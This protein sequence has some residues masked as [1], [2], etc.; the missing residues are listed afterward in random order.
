MVVV[1]PT[2]LLVKVAM[3]S[4]IHYKKFSLSIWDV[5][6]Y[7]WALL[8]LLW[9]SAHCPWFLTLPSSGNPF[10]R[11]HQQLLFSHFSLVLSLSVCPLVFP[12]MRHVA[13]GCGNGISNKTECCSAMESYV[14]HLQKQSLVTNLQALNCATTLGMKLQRSNI[15]KD[16]YSLC[17]ITLKDFSLQGWCFQFFNKLFFFFFSLVPSPKSQFPSVDILQAFSFRQI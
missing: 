7:F 12:D 10:S 8:I 1:H 5:L 17:H 6:L 16:V 13:K 14:S 2:S 9:G 4:F 3:T 11:P 15:T